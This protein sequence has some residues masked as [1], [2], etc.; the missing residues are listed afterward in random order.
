MLLSISI[1]LLVVCLS[2]YFRWGRR[3]VEIL[4]AVQVL[5][6]NYALEYNTLFSLHETLLGELS[7]LIF[8]FLPTLSF[9]FFLCSNILF[10]KACNFSSIAS[11]HPLS[12]L[13]F[14]V[15]FLKSLSKVRFL[16]LGTIHILGQIIFCF[17][18][19]LMSCIMFSSMCSLS[20]LDVSSTSPV[21]TI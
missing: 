1:F 10:T 13:L 18:S 16:N 19:C 12:F 2:S 9:L 15:R 17:G 11:H 4:F 5:S 3:M 20:L 6:L 14:I 21:V 8:F 7:L